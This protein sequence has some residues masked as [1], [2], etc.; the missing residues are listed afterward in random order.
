MK[1]LR[2]S[3]LLIVGGI[4]LIFLAA[5]LFD[6]PRPVLAFFEQKG[7]DLRF[8]LR[9][10]R[11]PTG[12]V[13]VAGIEAK[14]IDSYG[15]WP[16]PRSV[17]AQLLVRL[18]DYG[19]RTVIFD[20]L[21]PEAEENMIR[22]VLESL[23]Q[24]FIQLGLHTND[25]PNQIFHDEMDQVKS[26][27]DNDQLF[28]QAL[29]W[30][31]NVVLGTAF[32]GVRDDRD[33]T[34]ARSLAQA[35][36]GRLLEPVP[37]LKDGAW[38]LGFVNIFPDSDGTIRRVRPV[39]GDHVS[40]ALAGAGHYLDMAVQQK[41]DR[42]ILGETLLPLTRN[43][44]VLLNF[45]GLNPGFDRISIADIIDG[46]IAP[47]RVAGK[48]VIIGAMATGI[49]DIWPT[50]LTSEI[51]GVFIQA[52]L[53]D[54]ILENRLMRMPTNS[55]WLKAGS[56]LV[57]TLLPLGFMVRFSPLVSLSAGVVLMGSYAAGV[58][59]LFHAFDLV[60]P[61]MLPLGA[62]LTTVSVL[63]IF[64][65][66]TEIRQHQWVK[67]S[68]SRY[69]S[70][71]VI[72]ILIQHPD[73]LKLGGEEKELTVLMADIRNFTTLSE[74]LSPAELTDLLNRYL[75]ELTEVI[76][77]NGGTLDKYM[78]D[79]IMAFFGAPLDDSRHPRKACLTAIQMFE[80]LAVKQA[81]WQQQGIPVLS[82]GMGLSTGNVIVGNLGSRRR[83]DY[84]VIGDNVNLASRL[85]GLCKV[86]GVKII[87]PEQTRM[88]LDAS[89]VCR[90]LDLVR[91][92]GRQAPV[93]IYEL[94]GKK[95]VASA[96]PAWVIDFEK[97]LACYRNQNFDTAMRHF[98]HVRQSKPEDSPAR[99]F[100]TR[101]RTLMENPEICEHPLE[102][103]QWD[104]IWT[105]KEK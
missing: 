98:E 26:E 51:P 89:F 15:R 82:L 50:P 44:N 36:E 86:Y 19:A 54:N 104:G 95:P 28:S 27:F 100:I 69:L 37:Q 87:I 46:A 72:D 24:S 79:A 6:Q 74:T 85:E 84:S 45:Y 35:G 7:L 2:K 4:L 31:G 65:F 48:V 60:W 30:S 32:E 43:G 59:F 40:L 81:K 53:L 66:A 97:G 49:G 103:D 38:G 76:L 12:Q 39:K 20:L 29:A 47:E 41:D 71:A 63:L 10:E 18:K 58:Q 34:A 92:K 21:F 68:F 101:C 11:L 102:T 13:V 22:P 90:E 73:Q 3:H 91:V 80:R 5:G 42:V 77:E 78:G 88:H 83:F 25:F 105:F 70:P 17:F 9:G 16:W 55:H 23:Q 14:G 57:M 75:G 61:L 64:N 94:I 99:L 56:V 67:K 52:T 96:S 62:C 8:K 1:K 33:Y 93:K